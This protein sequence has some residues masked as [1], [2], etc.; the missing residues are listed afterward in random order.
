M[1]DL[2]H[3]YGTEAGNTGANAFLV[4]DALGHKTLAMTGGYVNKAG[5]AAQQLADRVAGMPSGRQDPAA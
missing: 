5:T 3:G 2:R 1:H 4:R